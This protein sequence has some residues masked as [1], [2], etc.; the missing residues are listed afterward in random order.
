MTGA[1]DPAQE[2]N[3]LYYLSCVPLFKTV[4]PANLV[5]LARVSRW[6]KVQRGE[7]LFLQGD[8]AHS[9]FVICTGWIVIA[10]NSTDGRELVITEMRDG[11]LFGENALISQTARSTSAIA[12][13]VTDVL[14]IPSPAFLALL[15]NEPH[16][17]RRMLEIS[18]ARLVASNHRQSALAFLNAPARL[19]RVLREMGETDQQIAHQGY[20]TLSQEELAQRTGLTRQTVARFLGEWRRNGWLQTG[21]GHI[22]LLNRAELLNIEEQGDF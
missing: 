12:R 8:P 7:F 18:V 10:L 9:A 17:V 13:T 19:A 15:D 3:Y 22:T 1:P 21:R 11:D 4:S 14:E 2:S 5:S 16:L 20:V 6:R